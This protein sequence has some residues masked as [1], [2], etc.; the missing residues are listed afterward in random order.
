[1]PAHP[2]RS[3]AV[4]KMSWTTCDLARLPV[5]AAAVALALFAGG[6]LRLRRRA[7]AR[8]ADGWRGP[9][10]VLAVALATLP[11]ISP[12]DQAGDEYP[13]SPHLVQHVPLR[14][15]PPAPPPVAL[16]GPLLL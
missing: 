6:L 1:M 8:Y 4:G 7:G 2:C 10:F 9:L 15:A 14:E 13:L 3:D 5:V 16:R 12:L 11:V